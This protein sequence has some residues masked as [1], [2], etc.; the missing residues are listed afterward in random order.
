MG[1]SCPQS[2]AQKALAA[3]LP[4]WSYSLRV[5]AKEQGPALEA[6]GFF[7]LV[8]DHLRPSMSELGYLPIDGY[9]NDEPASRG[10]NTTGVGES[11]EV[12]FRWFEYGFEAGSDEAKLL[13]RPDDPES[14]DE[15]WV[16]YEPA[17]GLLE[18]DDWASVA[19]RRVDWDIRRDFGPC[20]P[21][22]VER[23]LIAL[24]HAVSGFVREHTTTL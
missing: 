15:L 1:P 5:A 22:A 23:R 8:E 24:G 10:A 18:L 13:V 20:P 9:V 6:Q 17:T 2:L 11:G 16:N 3:D 14:G 7:E 19:G 4:A 21:A 12:P